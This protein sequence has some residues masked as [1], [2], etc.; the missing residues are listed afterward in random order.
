MSTKKDGKK[1]YDEL[2]TVIADNLSKLMK[3]KNISQKELAEKAGVSPTTISRV[4]HK[5]SV[6]LE[7]LCCL[8]AALNCEFPELFCENG[9]AEIKFSINFNPDRRTSVEKGRELI[10]YANR[11]FGN[12][13]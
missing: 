7:T 10:D 4:M 2:L 11:L 9:K 5:S 12:E 3:K 8:Q 13:E 1:L 6:N